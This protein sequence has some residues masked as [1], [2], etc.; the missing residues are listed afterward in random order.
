MIN[1]RKRKN[2]QNTNEMAFVRGTIENV[3]IKLK[4]DI[5]GAAEGGLENFF[6]QTKQRKEQA[7]A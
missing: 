5:D 7:K 1:G 6:K 4:E 2:V 3:E